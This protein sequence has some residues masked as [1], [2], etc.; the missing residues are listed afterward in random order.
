[1]SSQSPQIHPSWYRVLSAEFNKSY[2]ISLK[3]SLLEEKNKFT[4]YPPGSR[5]FA[6]FDS[7]PFD[8]V[9]V[10]IIG[11][12]PYHGPGQANGL[13]FSVARGVKLP[14]SLKNIYKELNSD[15]N[16]PVADHGDLQQWA[17]Q[18]VLML[19]AFLTVRHR[20]PASHR[21]LGW[22]DFTDEVIRQL[23][24]NRDGIVFLLWGN[25]AKS[26]KELIDLEKHFVLEAPHPSPYSANNGF[27]GCRHFSRTNELLEQQSKT[28]INWQL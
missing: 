11:Q 7:T 22:E 19:N 5:I 1:M 9:K 12:D 13:S 26:K 14:P 18:G 20:T 2:F 23:S 28:P 15:L 10:V 4:T 25:F 17:D 16:I 21:K 6:A 3:N 8:K 24:K 27:F